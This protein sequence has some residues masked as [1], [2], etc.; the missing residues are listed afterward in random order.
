MRYSDWLRYYQA[1]RDILIVTKTP[2]FK[3]IGTCRGTCVCCAIF[4]EII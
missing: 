1:V 3:K 2:A 4:V